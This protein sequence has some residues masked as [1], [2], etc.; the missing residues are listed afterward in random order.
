[1]DY[2][3]NSINWTSLYVWFS[4]ALEHCIANAEATG[5][6]PVE[7]PKN[8][9]RAINLQLFLNFDQTA[10]VI[11]SLNFDDLS[12]RPLRNQEKTWTK[13]IEN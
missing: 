10:M 3:L 2:V 6:N 13:I 7:T 9:F 5:S 1:M 4:K 11:S 8:F 12:C